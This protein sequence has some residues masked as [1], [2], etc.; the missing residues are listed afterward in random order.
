MSVSLSAPGANQVLDD[1]LWVDANLGSALAL[2][3][4]GPSNLPVPVALADMT[5][6]V[7][8]KRSTFRRVSYSDNLI[9]NT[10]QSL[11]LRRNIFADVHVLYTQ[12]RIVR[13]FCAVQG[14]FFYQP[15]QYLLA[16]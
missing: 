8:L 16:F 14:F 10:R 4:L 3:T 5:M 7:T 15:L 1:M 13:C 2:Q 12:V 9:T 6:S 11:S